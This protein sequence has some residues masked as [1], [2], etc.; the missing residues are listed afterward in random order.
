MAESAIDESTLLLERSSQ[1]A[2]ALYTKNW[3]KLREAVCDLHPSDIADLVIA[4][5]MQHEGI[6]FRVLPRQLATRVFAY[7]PHEY[8]EEL[9]ASLSGREVE[10]IINNLSDDDR[11]RL[12]EELPAAVTRELLNRLSPEELKSARELLGYPPNTAGRYMTPH[13]VSIRPELTAA[14]ALEHV[15]RTGRNQETLAVVYIVDKDGRLVEDI[16]L[17]SLVLADPSTRVTEIVDPELVALPA[18]ANRE[19]VL[20]LF[21]KY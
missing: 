20:R 19:E 9:L 10:E 3:P 17:G 4:L 11:T 6:L 18:M 1:I 15:R 5:P 21:E 8:Q 14:E 16:R 7:L 12:F 2:D 13:Y